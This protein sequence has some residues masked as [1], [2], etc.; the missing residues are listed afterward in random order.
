MRILLIINIV[1]LLLFS[2]FHSNV[3]DFDFYS[4]QYRSNGVYEK[5]GED[6]TNEM[7][8]DLF[9]F[10]KGKGELDTNFFN[11]KEL[12]H[13]EDVKGLFT[14]VRGLNFIFLVT[15]IILLYFT[16]KKKPLIDLSKVFFWTG[17]VISALVLILFSLSPFFDDIFFAFHK[18]SFSNTDW[19]LNPETDNLIVMFPQVFFI[20]ITTKIVISWLLNG[21][22]FFVMALMIRY[23]KKIFKSH[24]IKKR[25]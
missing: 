3:Y 22:L 6:K 23:H 9:R 2:A 17:V 24:M 8:E 7:T 15:F 5:F 1:V 10:L 21:M 25:R 16:F 11:A 19:L 13:M 20:A 18:I 14:F 4:E 12:R